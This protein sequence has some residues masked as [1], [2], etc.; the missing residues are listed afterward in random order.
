MSLSIK[1][2]KKQNPIIYKSISKPSMLIEIEEVKEIRDAIQEH[3]LFQIVDKVYKKY[4]AQQS[5][6]IV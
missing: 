1:I 3:L 6:F 2:Q 4:F 5:F